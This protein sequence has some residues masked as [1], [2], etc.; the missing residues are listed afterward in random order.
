MGAI[1]ATAETLSSRQAVR[2]WILIPV[3][4][5]GSNPISTASGKSPLLQS[6]FRAP[7]SSSPISNWKLVG[8][9]VQHSQERRPLPMSIALNINV[10]LPVYN[11]TPTYKPLPQLTRRQRSFFESAKAA[12]ILSDH[13]QFHLGCVIVEGSRII[14]SGCNSITRCSPIQQKLDHNR[15]GGE[16]RGVCHAETAALLPL[17]RQRADLAS[18]T[19]YLYRSH[20]DGSL[21]ISRPCSGCMS[22]L[23]AVGIRRVF[24]TVE[25][26]YAVEDI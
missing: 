9:V 1:A 12:S 21:A 26:G 7:A 15:F 3:F 13:P 22:L 20:K 25:G 14:S 11:K 8:R 10:N 19:A 24:F 16:H 2:H 4:S 5:I 18:C 17:I 23:R 6:I